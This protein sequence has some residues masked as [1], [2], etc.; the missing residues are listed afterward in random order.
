ME[1]KLLT[2]IINNIFS[3]FPAFTSAW[4]MNMFNGNL[5]SCSLVNPRSSDSIKP[6]FSYICVFIFVI[7]ISL[8]L[9]NNM[10]SKDL[11]ETFCVQV[12]V[13]SVYKK[14][15]SKKSRTLHIIFVDDV[16][17]KNNTWRHNTWCHNT[18]RHDKYHIRNWE[19]ISKRLVCIWTFLI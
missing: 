4:S 12:S 15:P 1:L 10:F 17:I 3:T 2:K 8:S 19:A 16:I 13:I 6:K 5:I 14:I 7:I 9:T 18:W 11:M